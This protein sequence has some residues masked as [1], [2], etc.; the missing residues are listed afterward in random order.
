MSD[1]KQ[2]IQ[3]SVTDLDAIKDN[4][5]QAVDAFARRY[6]SMP[7]FTERCEVMDQSQLRDA[8]GLRATFEYGDPW[9]KAEQL[10]MERGF[11]WHN[12]GGMRVMFVMERED[13]LPSE[14]DG[15][16]DGVDVTTDYTD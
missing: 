5:E 12:L 13:L 10:L 4:T 6:L 8:M 2:D 11:R 3:L 15:W 16:N 14:L 1:E 7:R 9:P